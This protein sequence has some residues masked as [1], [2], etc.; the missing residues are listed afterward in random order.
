MNI[1]IL[2]DNPHRVKFFQ[3]GLKAHH[4]T[5]C[6]HASAAIAALKT[7][8][9]EVIFLDHDL[10]G[11]PTDPEDENCGSEVAR[12]IAEQEIACPCIIVHT[13]NREGRESMEAILPACEAIPYSKLKK[14]GL[15]K[16]IQVG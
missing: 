4:L 11:K 12:F 8:V 7:T 15:S 16:V 13:E 1:L 14:I 3:N 5:V 2:D 9:F 6:R 10:N